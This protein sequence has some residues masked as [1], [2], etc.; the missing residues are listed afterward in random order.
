MTNLN[1]VPT[2]KPS[3][4][5]QRFFRDNDFHLVQEFLTDW[6]LDSL[7][8]EDNESHNSS[9]RRVSGDYF[10]GLLLLLRDLH[11]ATVN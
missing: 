11:L 10:K 2:P 6:Y 4:I 8:H 1:R 3:L 7:S 9:D 5:A